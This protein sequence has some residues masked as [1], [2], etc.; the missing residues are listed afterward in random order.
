MALKKDYETIFITDS[1][2]QNKLPIK[3]GLFDKYIVEGLNF[4]D[5]ALRY[6]YNDGTEKLVPIVFEKKSL[7]DLWGTMVPSKTDPTSYQRF[8]REMDRAKK[9]EFKLVLIITSSMEDV[10]TGCEYSKFTGEA[11]LKKLAMLYVRYDLEYI[12]CNSERA[13]ARRIEDT[14][15]AINRNYK[16]EKK[17][18][19][20]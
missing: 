9:H 6:E 15:S 1:R 5:Y 7:N 19:G 20:K 4:G 3:D 10:Y 17:C 11:M 12:F 14:F 13:A 16:A 18:T 8:K 2:E